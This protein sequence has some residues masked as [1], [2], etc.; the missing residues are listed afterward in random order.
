VAWKPDLTVAAVIA[1]RGRF[2]CV[3]ERI[4]SRL[5]FNQP[6]GHV[7]EGE[8]LVQAIMREVAEETGC[9]FEPAYLLGIYLWRDSRTQHTTL[10][11]AFAGT[12]GERDVSRQL[13]TA[14][15]ATHWLSRAELEARAGR[16][17]SPLVMRCIDDYL[18]GHRLPLESVQC[19][20]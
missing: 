19:S 11:F 3:E 15:V 17:R 16:L 8:T 5:V 12:A 6:A 18:A 2:L 4:R 14:I 13:D 10:R 20:V 9:L 1:E 7:E